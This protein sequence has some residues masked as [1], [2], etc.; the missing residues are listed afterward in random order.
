MGKLFLLMKLS[1]TL[2]LL[3][4]LSCVLYFQAGFWEQ[5]TDYIWSWNVYLAAMGSLQGCWQ[6]GLWALL[7]DDDDG[8]Y[9]NQC[10]KLYDG[11]K[12]NFASTDMNYCPMDAECEF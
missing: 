8:L 9:I 4:L 2:T 5:L 10:L 6:W 1:R 12:V 3:A 7:F 11:A